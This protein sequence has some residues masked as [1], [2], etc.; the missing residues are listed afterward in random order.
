MWNWDANLDKT[1]VANIN[2]STQRPYEN[3][4]Y[5][6]NC[7]ITDKVR[8]ADYEHKSSW[9]QKVEKTHVHVVFKDTG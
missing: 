7:I 8:T 1:Y 6:Q 5:C 9:Q 3:S 4:H 2:L